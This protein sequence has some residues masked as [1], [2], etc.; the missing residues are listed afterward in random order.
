MNSG[1]TI[2]LTRCIPRLTLPGLMSEI[3]AMV[4]CDSIMT[5]EPVNEL[6]P[7]VGP[8]EKCLAFLDI[9][10]NACS[11]LLSID[12]VSIANDRP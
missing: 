5:V 8:S 9:W 2:D 12:S 10:A 4:E 1:C 7:I 3:V 11:D 6:L